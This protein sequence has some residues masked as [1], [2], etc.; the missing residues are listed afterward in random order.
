MGKKVITLTMGQ[1]R[2]LVEWLERL[3]CWML[4]LELLFRAAC[5]IKTINTFNLPEMIKKTHVVVFCVVVVAI[6]VVVGGDVVLRIENRL[7]LGVN[8]LLINAIL[9]RCCAGCRVVATRSCC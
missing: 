4:L 1:S 9:P 7:N 2:L 3:W 5:A 8:F 6:V